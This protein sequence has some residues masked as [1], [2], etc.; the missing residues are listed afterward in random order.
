MSS[1]EG[2]FRVGVAGVG[3]LGFHH[4]RILQDLPGVEAVGFY[5]PDQNRSREVEDRLGL[6]SFSSLEGLLDEVEGL[7]VATPTST[8]EEVATTAAGRGIHLF[9]E[10]PIAPTLESADRILEEAEAGQA[11]VQ[12][13]HVERFNPAVL[14]AEPYLD[15]PLFVESHRLAPFSPRGTDVAV[16]LD[17]MIHDVDLVHNLIRNPVSEIAAAGVPVLTPSVDIANAR[18]SW[19]GGAVANLTASRVSTERMRKIRI[20]QPSGYLSLDLG[21][22]SGRFLRLKED[23]PL[24]QDRGGELQPPQGLPGDLLDLV[25][26]IPLEV[27]PVEPLR[28]ELED[29]RDCAQNGR[30]PKVA[31]TDGRTALALALTI[32]E[33]ISQ[34]VANSRSS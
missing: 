19:E 34:H 29:F 7:V 14:A 27:D 20:F 6:R 25:E 31:G 11:I 3:S 2:G 13:G 15:T 33:R 16:V 10:K 32:E 30:R 12:V 4:G 24:L 28:R 17:L 26:V 8:H 21:E 9:I 5:D 23:I 18:I 22:G 1:R